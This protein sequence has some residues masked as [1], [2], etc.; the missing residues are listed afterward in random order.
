MD[1]SI[2]QVQQALQ[3][4]SPDESRNEWVMVGMALKAEFGAAGF[5]LFD[6]WS[7]GSDKYKARDCRATWK[8]IKASGGVGIGTL[9]KKAKDA[10]W[11]PVEAQRDET[12]QKAYRAEMAAR[13]AKAQADLAAEEAWRARMADVVAAGCDAL[14]AELSTHDAA[15]SDYLTRKGV[16]A[17]GVFVAARSVLLVTDDAACSWQLLTGEADIKAFYATGAADA[18]HISVR[19]IKRGCVVVPL[20]NANYQVRAVQV[21]FPSGKKSFPRHG[22]KS[23][24][25]HYIGN[26][27]LDG[28]TPCLCVAEG[29]A[30][31]ASIHMATGY[32][33]VVALDA[34]NLKPVA[35]LWRS[36]FPALPMLVC[37]DNDFKTKDN[38]GLVHAKAAAEAAGA[39]VVIPDFS[40]V[41][42]A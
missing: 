5:D 21:I 1:C 18:E 13:R 7:Q 24:C 16:L 11:R 32:P 39:G 22:E 26:P 3:Y 17:F 29:Y 41:V 6:G 12:A 2:D 34:G 25:F 36:W 35:Q 20:R 27:V 38:P 10:G 14:L 37:G 23:G 19:H 42:A 40:G 33:V 28:S 15:P 8:S 4:V 31:A 9:F 30:T